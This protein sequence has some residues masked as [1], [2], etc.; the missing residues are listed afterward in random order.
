MRS[1]LSA[2]IPPIPLLYICQLVKLITGLS[3]RVASFSPPLPPAVEGLLAYPGADRIFQRAPKN[4]ARLVPGPDQREISRIP[5]KPRRPCRQH[6]S[7]VH[8]EMRKMSRRASPRRN[9]PVRSPDARS[10]RGSAPRPDRA[11]PCPSQSQSP[12]IVISRAA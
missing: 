8:H 4:A 5:I 12:E 9:L 10:R 11:G 3:C 7:A 2:G 6:V 1:L